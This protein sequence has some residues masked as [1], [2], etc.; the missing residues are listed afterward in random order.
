MGSRIASS[1]RSSRGPLSCHIRATRI[2]LLRLLAW[3]FSV[4]VRTTADLTGQ[5]AECRRYGLVADSCGVLVD[6][7]DQRGTRAGVPEPGHQFLKARARGSGEGAACMPKIVKG[8]P[9]RI[10]FHA[11]LDP[12]ART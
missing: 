7:L 5:V 3:L 6:Q 11:G 4:I 12:D 9:R 8:H 1:A 10:G 2:S